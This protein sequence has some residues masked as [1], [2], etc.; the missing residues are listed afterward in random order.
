MFDCSRVSRRHLTTALLG[1]LVG[2]AATVQAVRWIRVVRGISRY[3]DYW[4]TAAGGDGELLYVALGDSL[5]QGVGASGPRRGYVGLLAERVAE[6]TGR[7]V[8]VVNLSVTGVMLHDLLRDQL[9]VLA[10][11]EPDLVTVAIGAND[12]GRT[13]PGVF[14]SRFTALC[15]ALPAGSLVADVPDFQGGSRR[16][17]GFVLS[18]VAREVLDEHPALVPVGLEAA[19]TAMRWRDYSADL[20]HPGDRGYLRYVEPFWHAAQSAIGATR[21]ASR[22]RVPRS[23]S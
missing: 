22:E 13:D 9:P 21:D 7:T 1:V 15:R 18:R 5:A 12:A 3:R 19:T 23:W 10:E 11:L 20:F 14:R 8:R 4:H 6:A 17:A 2:A 16:A